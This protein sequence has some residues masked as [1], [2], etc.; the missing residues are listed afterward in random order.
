MNFGVL[1]D[2]VNVIQIICIKRVSF[3]SFSQ[4][5]SLFL[6]CKSRN[7]MAWSSSV[8]RILWT[9]GLFRMNL[10]CLKESPGILLGH[11]GIIIVA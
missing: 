3:L 11:A 10:C 9:C 2:I 1:F 4:H 8:R 7:V 6:F 5:V